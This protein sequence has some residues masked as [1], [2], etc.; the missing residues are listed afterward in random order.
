MEARASP[1][2]HAVGAADMKRIGRVGS[3]Q[4]LAVIGIV[5]LTLA[6]AA[7]GIPRL[8]VEPAVRTVVA[9]AAQPS[10][11]LAAR[12]AGGTHYRPLS[13]GTDVHSTDRLVALPGAVLVSKNGKVTLTFPGDLSASAPWPIFDTACTLQ[14]ADDIDLD[15]SMETGRL[16]IRNTAA[17]GTAVLRLRFW[18]QTWTLALEGPE[19]ELLFD[20][21]SRWPA[22]IRFQPRPIGTPP[23]SPPA[24][25]AV[26]LVLKGNAS[27]DVGGVALA[28]SSPPGP[29]ELRWDSRHGPPQAAS[30]IEQLPAWADLRRSPTSQIRRLAEAFDRF[31]QTFLDDPDGALSRFARADDPLQRT[32]ALWM[33]NAFEEL[34]ILEGALRKPRSTAEW[35]LSVMLFRHWLS[36]SSAHDLQLYD[37]LVR[38]SYSEAE[39][40]II[41]QL[42]LGFSND[43]LRLPETYQ[44]LL[45]Y[46]IHEKPLVRNLAAWHLIRLIPDARRFPY[47]PD[48]SREDALRTQEQW[49][50]LLP[51]DSLPPSFKDK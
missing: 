22:G 35:D 44:V 34:E 40:R 18:N 13:A 17:A 6:L 1:L 45:D 23:P 31:R 24:A 33:A 20:L 21:S 14:A 3:R 50:K 25:T 7:E 39:A 19:T 26:L 47:K 42:L 37:Y 32:V 2:P 29:A 46:L 12:S 48:G 10:G 41:L 4:L 38:Q 15:L 9:K 8:E 36:R 11:A 27:V 43:D 30:K 16:V 49:R 28:L 51:L 5:G